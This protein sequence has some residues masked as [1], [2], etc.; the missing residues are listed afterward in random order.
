MLLFDPAKTDALPGE[1]EVA[2]SSRAILWAALLVSAGLHGVFIAMAP[3]PE[4]PVT[5]AQTQRVLQLRMM[6]SALGTSE[7]PAP[8][9]VTP[10]KGESVISN[11]EE[12][13][14]EGFS[15]Q[16]PAATLNKPTVNKP[17]VSITESLRKTLL[18]SEKSGAAIHC[19]PLQ[20]RQRLM[21]CGDSQFDVSGGY[22]SDSHLSR[23]LDST[24]AIT[25]SLSER[26]MALR[27][28]ELLMQR[29]QLEESVAGN[30]A[31]SDFLRSQVEA[32]FRDMR[33]QS[34]AQD[35]QRSSFDVLGVSVDSYRA[36]DSHTRNPNVFNQGRL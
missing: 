29:Q 3:A 36:S 1:R 31:E 33:H 24:L 4:Q 30:M 5:V 9:A 18:E 17:A 34:D 12:T 27:T 32:D 2:Q 11:S 15:R 23:S 7:A 10:L 25:P 8:P 22:S 6:P 35:R 16:N 13:H 20:K 21:D 26:A 14:T 28:R 19:T